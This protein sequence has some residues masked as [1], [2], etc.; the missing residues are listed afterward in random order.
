[1]QSL[2]SNFNSCFAAQISLKPNPIWV[3]NIQVCKEN[4]STHRPA[5]RKTPQFL[6]LFQMLRILYYLSNFVTS[7]KTVNCFFV[8]VN[9]PTVSKNYQSNYYF[10]NF[11]SYIFVWAILF[12]FLCPALFWNFLKLNFVRFISI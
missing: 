11:I 7:F 1:M 6:I 10:C 8:Y 3:T 12:L 9:S 4:Y 2:R 5:G